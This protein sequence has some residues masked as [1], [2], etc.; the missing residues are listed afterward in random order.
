[1]E[2]LGTYLVVKFT[3]IH[4]C[5]VDDTSRGEIFVGCFEGKCAIRLAANILDRGV[6]DEFDAVG[7]GIFGECDGELKRADDAAVGGMQSGDGIGGNIGLERVEFSA[8]ENAE[9]F[10]AIGF[11]AFEQLVELWS[12][13]SIDT[14]DERAISFKWDIQIARQLRH[15]AASNDIKM[16]LL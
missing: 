9:V 15:H 8:F 7:I 14:D 12:L 13:R 10:D 4:A 2:L 11:A 1:M 3:G 6:E 16:C 5:R